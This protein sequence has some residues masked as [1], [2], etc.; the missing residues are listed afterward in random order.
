MSLFDCKAYGSV[1]GYL[2]EKPTS[3]MPLDQGM[4]YN[5]IKN[6]LEVLDLEQ[7]F[8]P[9]P[10]V[11]EM[12]AEGCKSGL[13]LYNNFLDESHT[14]SQRIGT[15]TGS[16]WHA[17]MH[18]REPD[19]P[20][21]RYWFDRV[22]DHDIYPILKREAKKFALAVKE[23]PNEASYLVSLLVWDPFAFV[24]LCESS[25]LGRAP[26]GDLCRRIQQREWELLFDYCY[27][28]AIG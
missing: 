11:D 19:Y 23:L 18:R 5:E 26:A 17:I 1:F 27:Q 7:A 8:A 12:M 21:G 4:Q 15:P 14:L 6:E 3:I 24:D 22:G 10:I 16:Y 25:N 13:W 2:L 20:N 28:K 9:C